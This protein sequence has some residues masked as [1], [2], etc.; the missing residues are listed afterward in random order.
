MEQAVIVACCILAALAIIAAALEANAATF[1]VDSAGDASDDNTGDGICHT[2]GGVCTLRAA[3]QEVNVLAG[4]HTIEI[5]S[6]LAITFAGDA[7][8]TS[9]ITLTCQGATCCTGLDCSGASWPTSINFGAAA[10]GLKLNGANSSVRGCEVYGV[11]GS[12][13]N[14]YAIVVGGANSTATCNSV[15]DSWGGIVTLGSGSTIGGASS[16]D[17]NWAHNNHFGLTVFGGGS[18]VG[19]ITGTTANGLAADANV[20]GIYV[21]G[22]NSDTV[23]GNLASGNTDQGILVKDAAVTNTTISNNLVGVNRT[24]TGDLCNYLRDRPDIHQITD[25][26]TGTTLI[27]NTLGCQPTPTETPVDTPTPVPPECIDI[28][29]QDFGLGDWS[30]VDGS[31]NLPFQGSEAAMLSFLTGIGATGHPG[32]YRLGGACS[33]SVDA[34]A[35]HCV[36]PATPTDTAVPTNTETPTDTPTAT[37]SSTPSATPTVTPTSTPT[38]TL[39]PAGTARSLFHVRRDRLVPFARQRLFDFSRQRLVPVQQ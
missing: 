4:S 10:G 31:I 34:P 15:H 23:D 33:P 22:G 14:A 11:A 19:N 32:T 2:A 26:G 29:T 3:I 25:N 20:V 36:G 9:P 18:I 24:N 5:T 37:S 35:G 39:P 13:S 6:G 28:D 7:G 16:G 12:D 21:E 38:T 8:I 1:S 30:C 17:A 27:S